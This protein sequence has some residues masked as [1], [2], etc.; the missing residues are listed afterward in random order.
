MSLRLGFGLQP[1][2]LVGI[3][4]L[5]AHQVFPRF[6]NVFGHLGQQILTGRFRE[7][8]EPVVLGLVCGAGRGAAGVNPSIAGAD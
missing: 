4:A 6:G 1:P 2:A 5:I 7:P 8:P 3:P